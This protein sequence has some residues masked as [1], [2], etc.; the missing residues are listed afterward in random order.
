MKI[1]NHFNCL[2]ELIVHL[3]EK[4]KKQILFFLILIIFS[5][6]VEML[7]IA[8]VV[9]FVQSIT[10]PNYIG[11]NFF[12]K[13]IIAIETKQDLIITT[14]LLFA[15]LSI[16]NALVRCLLVYFTAK[17]SNA[18]TAEL[19]VKIFEA[20]LYEPYSSFINQS[21][22]IVI[23]AVTNK[24]ST[25]YSFLNST[26]NIISSTVILISLI[27]AL[28]WVNIVATV[29]S[30]TFFG[31]LY[32]AITV[33]SK[34]TIRRNGQIINNEQNKIVLSLQNGLGS[35][36]D[37]IL[38][39]AQNF[40]IDAFSKSN[41]KKAQRQA[42]GDVIAFSPRYIFEGMTI[43]LVVL[44]IFFYQTDSE[45][46]FNNLLTIF[47][48]LAAL[49]L[50]SQ[51]IIPLINSMHI[52]LVTIRQ[53]TFI[54]S[55]IISILNI[56]VKNKTKKAYEKKN[57]SF[58][59]SILFKNVFFSYNQSKKYIL[60]DINLEIKKGSRVGIVG[61]TGEGK[62]TLLDLLMGLLEP[63]SGYIYVDETKLSQETIDNWQSKVSHVPQKIFLSD[64]SYLAN[65]A[66]GKSI[67]NINIE[68]VILAAKKAQLND[69]IIK[70]EHGYNEKVGERGVKLSGGQIQRV[71]LARA[72]YKNSEII[73]F[74]EAT[75]SL[76]N[77]TENLIM[78]EVYRLD[79]NLTVIIVAHRLNTL[80]K[81]DVILEI[82]D[83][84]INQIKYN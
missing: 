64:D 12:F 33:F 14:S 41:F 83:K 22:S 40:Y 46:G 13:E 70:T 6:L 3:R 43:T 51:R 35:I 76:D 54:V 68:K 49:A 45:E 78:D 7:S 28:L 81:C 77:Y 29:V 17:L 18:I 34:K 10:D 80:Q 2:K 15:L 42:I 5:S 25:I 21:S 53:S 47:P 65:I 19:S 63:T 32:I 79:S 57:I 27:L 55:E 59:K 26:I 50:G 75:N 84:K 8:S 60:E 44:I 82:K 52:N 9:P 38:D 72:L 36:R 61:K 66:F 4:R 73:I 24:V 69:H 62:S 1:L 23:S 58:K 20:K 39:K 67:E 74:D 11:Q 71:G 16:L 31:I 56:I 48:T 30:L 37:I